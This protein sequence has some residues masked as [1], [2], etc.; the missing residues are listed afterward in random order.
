MSWYYSIIINLHSEF[1]IYE[2]SGYYRGSDC[3][4]LVYDITD[5][6]SFTSLENWR[7]EF[8]KEAAPE[9]PD[10]FPFI[11]VGTKHQF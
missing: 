8:L 7:G 11:L 1:I 3:C 6:R 4:I 5:S 9:D 2:G 10:K